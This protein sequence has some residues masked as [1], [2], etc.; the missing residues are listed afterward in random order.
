[1]FNFAEENSPVY[2]DVLL[3]RASSVGSTLTGASVQD[4]KKIL[5]SPAGAY[6]I[7]K[8]N[9]C[10]S[11]LSI[12]WPAKRICLFLHEETE[13]QQLINEIA[14]VSQ[15]TGESI[16]H[17]GDLYAIA[18][19]Q[20]PETQGILL[21]DVQKAAKQ[22]IDQTIVYLQQLW[23][24]THP[25]LAH[26]SIVDF[27]TYQALA[28]EQKALCLVLYAPTLIETAPATFHQDSIYCFVKGLERIAHGYEKFPDSE[29]AKQFQS[30]LREL[31]SL[32]SQQG[33]RAHAAPKEQLINELPFDL[34]FVQKNSFAPLLAATR[35]NFITRGTLRQPF[36]ELSTQEER[37]IA[38]NKIDTAI[39][40]DLLKWKD[41]YNAA[42][43]HLDPR[44]RYDTP[45]PT[46]NIFWSNFILHLRK[47][48]RGNE[49]KVIR[50]GL[51]LSGGKTVQVELK[52]ANNQP[53][54]EEADI[55]KGINEL[56]DRINKKGVAEVA[57]RQVGHHIV[58]DF[59]GSQA[60]SGTDL[61][62]AST[63]FFHIVNEKFSHP[64]SPL[65]QSTHQFLQEVWNEA[66]VTGKTEEREIQ[67]IARRHLYGNDS[68]HPT[69]KSDAARALLEQGLELASPE[70]TITTNHIDQKISKIA[71]NRDA[72]EMQGQSH[73]LLIVLNNYA[74]EGSYL[75][76]IHA[77]YDPSQGNY[78]S[79]QVKKTMS[80]PNG[81][82]KHP[83][84]E[85][86][87]WTSIFSKPKVS[88]TELETY[89]KG[90]GWR[91]AIILNGSV[92]SCPTLNEPLQDSAMI[93]G[94]F[95]QR[96]VS[97]LATD[98]QGGSL[99][100]TPHILSE[101][102]VSP[103]LG[104]ADRTKGIIATLIALFLVIASM[105]TYYRFAGLI[106]SAAVLLNLLIM[107]A[108][109]QQLGA[110]LSLAGIAGLI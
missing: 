67:E 88:G 53:V 21:L 5:S 75:E 30:D 12:D 89:S 7:G 43:V 102:N 65:A 81:I 2:Q 28:P 94:S 80:S 73:P 29:I 4:I 93:S 63:M 1:M 77:S 76:N 62:R 10:F 27:P 50:W 86:Q 44:M 48:L 64:A 56:Y 39:H 42:Q 26:L 95:S 71:I 104:K 85:L 34:M 23:H 31:L 35:E 16:N 100:F 17:E 22:L 32:L 8:L 97:Q 79:F 107:W 33:F 68:T 37:I 108:V 87:E 72:N 11:S 99:T 70:H 15:A 49:K 92:I 91:M 83:S 105:I 47:F 58:L 69:P 78:L 40:E 82:S 46:K 36:L 18:F 106:A 54:T 110:S 25:D 66:K 14:K 90:Q 98:L 103:E 38:E 57:I 3:D 24:P 20:K 51:D 59:P 55:K 6:T 74:L 52:N 84:K 13:P 101:K 41:E 45:K 61:V 9:P 109:L 19:H 96:E 60:L